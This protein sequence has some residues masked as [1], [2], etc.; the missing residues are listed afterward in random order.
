[1]VFKSKRIFDIITIDTIFLAIKKGRKDVMY[2]PSPDFEKFLKEF[3]Q[4]EY[5]RVPFFLPQIPSAME[6]DDLMVEEIVAL[7]EHQFPND[8]F[9]KRTIRNKWLKYLD[10]DIIT[11]SCPKNV[12][13]MLQLVRHVY[14]NG[15]INIEY[16][17]TMRMKI[18]P[19][20]DNAFG[21]F[22]YQKNQEFTKT[23]L[24]FTFFGC[25]DESYVYVYAV[26]FL[27]EIIR[28]KPFEE[29]NDIFG[30]LIFK[31]ILAQFSKISFCCPI[32]TGIIANYPQLSKV[33][34]GVF[35]NTILDLFSHIDDDK[36][37]DFNKSCCLM[38]RSFFSKSEIEKKL[39]DAMTRWRQSETSQFID[40]I[41]QDSFY[42][43]AE[44]I[45]DFI[46]KV[47]IGNVLAMDENA[48]IDLE[49]ILRHNIKSQSCD[50]AAMLAIIINGLAGYHLF[51]DKYQKLKK[52]EI[53]DKKN[54]KK[55]SLI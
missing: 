48:N 21:K 8:S 54:H 32:A 12:A 3:L 45:P 9:D 40:Q 38:E 44:A 7:L 52:V 53:A 26:N 50:L 4:Y 15:D 27:H 17:N 35:W 16:L 10:E 14:E 22:G 28:H 33:N 36:Y 31:K 25:K 6:T 1:M 37:K 18:Q 19:Y 2:T 23:L 13:S 42:C 47:W 5:Q 24:A 55:N 46:K 49:L 51:I 34:F 39:K 30:F 41:S 20:T 11:P 29:W 43:D